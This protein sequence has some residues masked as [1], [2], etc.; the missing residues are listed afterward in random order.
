M[1]NAAERSQVKALEKRARIHAALMAEVLK[2]IMATPQGRQWM[3]G[4]LE[5]CHIG[6]NPFDTNALRMA[7]N[8]GEANVGLRL[9]AEL[10]TACPDQYILMMRE[11][12]ERE[13][14]NDIADRQLQSNPEHYDSLAGDEGNGDG[15]VE[16]DA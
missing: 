11:H 4:L 7:H 16:R 1:T 13:L 14:A 3:F 9:W 15:R 5:M 12:R 2:G 10:Q 8:C 6:A